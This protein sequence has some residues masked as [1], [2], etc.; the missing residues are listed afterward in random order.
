MSMARSSEAEARNSPSKLKLIVRI[1]QLV[2]DKEDEALDHS[3]FE[4]E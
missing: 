3:C 2:A 4:E 1:G